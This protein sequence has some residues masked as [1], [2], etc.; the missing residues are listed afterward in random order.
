V[1]A[2]YLVRRA[3]RRAAVGLWKA[4]DEHAFLPY[5]IAI[6]LLMIVNFPN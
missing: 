5:A 6:V 1:I 2:R 3:V 4:L